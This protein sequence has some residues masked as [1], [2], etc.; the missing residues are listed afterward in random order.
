MKKVRLTMSGICDGNPFQISC[1]Q[2][3]L[4]LGVQK[5]SDTRCVGFI[6]GLPGVISI[7]YCQGKRGNAKQ[8][9]PPAIAAAP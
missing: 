5:S 8:F 4:D 7:A 3:C 6:N 9:G 1:A 2:S